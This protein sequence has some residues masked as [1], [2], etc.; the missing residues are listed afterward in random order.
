MSNKTI[1]YEDLSQDIAILSGGIPDIIIEQIMPMCAQQ[2][3]SESMSIVEKATGAIKDGKMCLTDTCVNDLM[4]SSRYEVIGVETVKVEGKTVPFVSR[5][6]FETEDML[7]CSI[8]NESTNPITLSFKGFEDTFERE[9][10]KQRNVVEATFI[11]APRR[12][13]TSCVVPRDS[14]LFHRAVTALCYSY[15][16]SM[17]GKDWT[18]DNRAA[19][20]L[21]SYNQLLTECKRKAKSNDTPNSREC[22]F[23]W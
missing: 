15:L 1:R 2:F 20:Y 10:P 19:F 16:Y 13:A 11:F 9:D 21:A 7:C 23:S 14:G 3:A 8:T 12:T 5:K 18:D 17:P 22:K 6:A 4:D